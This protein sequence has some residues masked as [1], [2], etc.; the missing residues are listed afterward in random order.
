[1]NDVHVAKWLDAFTDYLP[2]QQAENEFELHE[3]ANNF[4]QA[5]ASCPAKQELLVTEYLKRQ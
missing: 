2:A 1:M 5:F 4:L 3:A